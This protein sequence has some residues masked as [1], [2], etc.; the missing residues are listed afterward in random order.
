[1]FFK[2]SLCAGTFDKFHLG[3]QFLVWFV[4]NHSKKTVVIIARDKTVEK[5]KSHLPKNSEFDRMKRVCSEFHDFSDVKIRL[6]NK[7]GDFFQTISEISPD[8]IFLGY[9]QKFN[10]EKCKKKY[11][12]IA[13]VRVPKFFPEL[14]KSSKI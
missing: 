12:K 2:K 3:H 9:D 5:L 8:A 4:R 1:M 13:I 14:F 10:I 6:G 11:P 7:N